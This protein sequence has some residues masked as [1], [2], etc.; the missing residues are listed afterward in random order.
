MSD[1]QQHQEQASEMA[2]AR[3]AS[4]VDSKTISG[5]S[6]LNSQNPGQSPPTP[7]S[8]AW[9]I[10]SALSVG[11]IAAIAGAFWGSGGSAVS[12]PN[13]SAQQAQQRVLAFQARGAVKLP[14]ISAQDRASAVQQMALPAAAR[15]S[16][17]HDVEE[18]QSK[19]VWLTLWD[20]MV[21]D[22]DVIELRSAGFN[23]VVA[24][25]KAKQRIAVPT[26]ASGTIEIK[27]VRDGGGGITVAAE[28]E[29]GELPIPV[30]SPG[31]TVSVPIAP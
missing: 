30:M 27:G 18:G 12:D 15:Q 8:S 11:L 1:G 14:A 31:Q 24:L 6:L 19:L 28:T 2:E 22:G 16:L 29:Q 4:A 13:L 3:K 9:L 21:E 23:R 10:G 17:T 20:D 25:T 5:E 26:T 7:R